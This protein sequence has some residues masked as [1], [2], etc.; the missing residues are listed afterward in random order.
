MKSIE[1]ETIH[2]IIINKSRFICV[3]VPLDSKD[4]VKEVIDYYKGVYE[5]ATHYCT[6]YII[7]SYMKCDDDGEPS[8]T[9]GMPILNVLKNN[10]LN[11]VLCIVIRY[12]G[13]IKLGAGGLVRAYSRSVSEGIKNTNIINLTDGY[14]MEISFN[15]DD[16]KVIDN[17]LKDID[18]KKEF[19]EKIVY[20]FKI[21]LGDYQ[22]IENIVNEKCEIINKE[23][24][25]VKS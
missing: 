14:Y 18:V 16:I 12:F 8:G 17:S 24:M 6:A 22:K 20:S 15:Y 5:G 11:H 3:L 10:E 25:M 13:G 19:G 4:A 9:A 2:E 1:N 21:S 23:S 7:D